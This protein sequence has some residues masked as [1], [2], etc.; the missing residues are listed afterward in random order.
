MYRYYNK[1]IILGDNSRYKFLKNIL[2]D[3]VY[4]DEDKLYKNDLNIK[5]STKNYIEEYEDINVIEIGIN[6]IPVST[7]ILIPSSNFNFTYNEKE[8]DKLVIFNSFPYGKE[9]LINIYND[10]LKKYRIFQSLF[11]L[12]KEDRRF[13][14][15]DLTSEEEAII[16]ARKLYENKNI[17]NIV[18][19]SNSDFNSIFRLSPNIIEAF[20]VDYKNKI[21]SVK[22]NLDD[23][24][25]NDYE[26]YIK[27]YFDFIALLND[28]KYSKFNRIFNFENIKNYKTI[29][30]GYVNNFEKQYLYNSNELI[31]EIRD[32]YME[33]IKEITI[34][35]KSI[36]IDNLDKYILSVYK[37]YFKEEVV[38][39]TP[40][41]ELEYIKLINYENEKNIQII[42]RK[43]LEEFINFKLK[44]A[45]FKYIKEKINYISKE[46]GEY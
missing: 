5:Y 27:N 45:L 34:F 20:K 19:N 41:T 22:E 13:A 31:V 6:L 17:D 43:K 32:F 44:I 26:L 1:V 37:D 28:D 35:N 12:Y 40:E 21:N 4:I 24:Y 14:K 2:K 30:R 23:N 46:I 16:N 11:V 29:W 42:F 36:E 7:L 18:Y 25:N 33:F 39:Y 8:I 38:L 3:N 10:I 15:G 9:D